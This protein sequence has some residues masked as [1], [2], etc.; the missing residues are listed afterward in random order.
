MVAF[1]ESP[2]ELDLTSR[3]QN[4]QEGPEKPGASHAYPPAA[5]LP[6]RI[7]AQSLWDGAHTIQRCPRR[8]APFCSQTAGV[9]RSF[10]ANANK[11][12]FNEFDGS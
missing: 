11:L 12:M 10:K 8:G 4:A 3:I 9:R 6:C 1:M 5:E 2:V 7:C